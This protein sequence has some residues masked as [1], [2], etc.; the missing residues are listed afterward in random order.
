M[1]WLGVEQCS[2]LELEAIGIAVM[3]I[4]EEALL[5]TSKGL[6]YYQRDISRGAHPDQ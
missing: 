3:P 4:R 5:T 6:V 2:I 1:C